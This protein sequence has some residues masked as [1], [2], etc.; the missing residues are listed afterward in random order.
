MKL[1]FRSNATARQI[2]EVHA[3]LGEAHA[4]LVAIAIP[5]TFSASLTRASQD[6]VMIMAKTLRR[7]LHA[8]E[9][10]FLARAGAASPFPDIGKP[11]R[12]LDWL[13]AYESAPH[14]PA[15][16]HLGGHGRPPPDRLTE[17]AS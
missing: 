13:D 11:R 14:G 15:A 10:P 12:W 17:A 5:H 3:R 4:A 6:S 7:A 16:Q 2:A 1:T 9:A 8:L